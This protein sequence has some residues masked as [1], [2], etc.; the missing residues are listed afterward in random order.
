MKKQLFKHVGLGLFLAATL[1][2]CGGGG[3]SPGAT[4][5]GAGTMPVNNG[6]LTLVMIDGNANPT[7]SL[8]GT[9]ILTLRATVLDSNASAAA[10]TVRFTSNSALVNILPTNGIASTNNQGVATVN[11]SPAS[12]SSQGMVTITA[13]ASVNGNTVDDTIDISV[14]GGR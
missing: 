13:T 5:P 9:S 2:A 6:M 10:T 14:N 1:G 3:G 11:I 4:G 12:T 8:S 7:S